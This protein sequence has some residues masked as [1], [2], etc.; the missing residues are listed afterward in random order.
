MG[1]LASL[2]VASLVMSCTSSAN[3]AKKRNKVGKA[4]APTA[5]SVALVGDSLA[6]EAQSYLADMVTQSKGT[7]DAATFGGWAPCDVLNSIEALVK[8]KPKV[9][10]LSFSGNAITSCMKDGE[11][12][13]D[14][15]ELV[16]RYRRDIITLR[17]QFPA[18]RVVLA[19]Q[20][21]MADPGSEVERLNALYTALAPTMDLT[22]TADA[23]GL[24]RAADGGW[25][26]SLPC[27]PVDSAARG[28]KDGSIVV[29]SPDKGHFCPVAPAP[30]NGVIEGC[31]QW[32]SGAFR[33]AYKIWEGL[34]LLKR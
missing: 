9:L 18:S 23:G 2:V 15:D 27:L 10:V 20:P 28:C 17:Q 6:W 12:Y 1:L 3:A 26:H 33:F 21:P 29:R 31:P 4:A 11:R 25:S 19:L 8:A 16:E 5:V 32:S 22:T 13:L 34:P 14:G 7:F 24:L 30:V